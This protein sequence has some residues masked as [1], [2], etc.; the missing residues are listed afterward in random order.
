MPRF[1]PTGTSSHKSET[2]TFT[3]RVRRSLP[4]SKDEDKDNTD[5]SSLDANTSDG[6]LFDRRNSKKRRKVENVQTTPYHCQTHFLCQ[7]TFVMM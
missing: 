2:K 7:S 4:L 3:R 1:T 6:S 5:G